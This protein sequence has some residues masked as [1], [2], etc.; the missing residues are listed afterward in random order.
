[1][2]VGRSEQVDRTTPV[3]KWVRE[4]FGERF[5]PSRVEAEREAVALLN[6]RVGKFSREEAGRLGQ[7]FNRHEKAGRVRRDRFLPGFAGATMAKLT[8][9]LERFNMLR[10]D[11]TPAA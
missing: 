1:M 4:E 3:L 7:L 11:K 9:D 6:A 10:T 5:V 8:E 2:A